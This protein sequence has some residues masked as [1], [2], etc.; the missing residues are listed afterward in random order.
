[1]EQGSKGGGASGADDRTQSLVLS[2]A[3]PN[4][5]GVPQDKP[6]RGYTYSQLE[7]LSLEAL[8]SYG[9]VK[10]QDGLYEFSRAENGDI[11]LKKIPKPQPK[12]QAPARCVILWIR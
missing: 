12:S 10:M 7:S 2:S 11:N 5:S 3:T 1:M 6:Y 8:Y 4:V 9:L